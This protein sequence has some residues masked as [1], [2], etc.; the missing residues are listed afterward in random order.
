MTLLWF[1]EDNQAGYDG[2]KSR[3]RTERVAL[4]A[5]GLICEE[6]ECCGKYRGK[7]KTIRVLWWL[8]RQAEDH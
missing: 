7:L 2:Y 3:L 4:L 6:A 1:S 8:R 5:N